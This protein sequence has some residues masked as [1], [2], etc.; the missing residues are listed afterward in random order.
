MIALGNDHAGLKLKETIIQV[1]EDLGLAYQDVGTNS[2]ESCDY[3]L[4]GEQA[5]RL[6]ASGECE[7]GI[8]ICGTGIGIGLAANKVKGIRC[9]MVSD[10]YSAQMA[11]LHN[12]CNMIAL[13][14]RVV[15]PG[16][17]ELIVRTF[18]AGTFEGGRHQRRVNQIAAIEGRE[19]T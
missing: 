2:P 17:A 8:V 11:R 16:A 10:P 6:V 19:D 4:I 15:G 18:L 1:L 12:D 3:P 5:A 7:L 13:G 9:A 14:G